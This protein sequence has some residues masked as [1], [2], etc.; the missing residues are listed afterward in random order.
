MGGSKVKKINK[1]SRK[2]YWN[3]KNLLRFFKNS[4]IYFLFYLFPSYNMNI[5]PIYNVFVA[6]Q[7][8]N[9][10]HLYVV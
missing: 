6:D 3:L 7:L 9:N 5:K 8:N 10:I 4:F 2:S 1:M